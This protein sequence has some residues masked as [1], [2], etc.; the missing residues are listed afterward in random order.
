MSVHSNEPDFQRWT[1][2]GGTGEAG[3]ATA[4][5]STSSQDGTVPRSSQHH[6]LWLDGWTEAPNCDR[7]EFPPKEFWTKKWQA[8]QVVRYIPEF[9]NRG[10][11]SLWRGFCE[12]NAAIMSKEKKGFRNLHLHTTLEESSTVTV[13][14][15]VTSKSYDKPRG[16]FMIARLTILAYSNY[17]LRKSTNTSCSFRN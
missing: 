14:T 15:G 6:Y 1:C 9:D 13:V 12:K 4:L 8:G 17:H 2:N 3:K 10:A 16:N 11:G 5:Y 7:D